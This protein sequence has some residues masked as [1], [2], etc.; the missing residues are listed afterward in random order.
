MVLHQISESGV[1][2]DLQETAEH[3]VEYSVEN[4]AK[5][6]TEHAVRHGVESTP[7]RSTMSRSPAYSLWILIPSVLLVIFEIN[8]NRGQFRGEAVKTW[9]DLA[10]LL[11]TT[12]DTYKST[13]ES[14]PD[15][16]TI[17]PTMSQLVQRI[18]FLAQANNAFYRFNTFVAGL[19]L[20]MYMLGD[21]YG[22][23]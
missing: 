2:I 8:I 16:R 15:L 13:A 9:R 23:S 17:C 18:C 6:A 3:A 20:T 4:A 1:K 21:Q 10:R 7:L 12:Q 14:T 5:K 22:G 11:P 19:L